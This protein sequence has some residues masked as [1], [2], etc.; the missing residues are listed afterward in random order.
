M[1]INHNRLV[2]GAIVYWGDIV[3]DL[4][5]QKDLVSYISTHGGGGGGG[6]DAAWGSI[7]GNISDQA[8]LMSKFGE[9]A[10]ESFVTSALTG[11]ATQSWVSEQ[12]YLTTE[13][14]SGY[15]TESWVESQGYLTAVPSEYATESWVESQGYL[16]A[17]PSGYAT[18]SWVESQGY[19]TEH[20]DLTGYATESWV[21]SQGYLTSVPSGYATEQFVTN[22]LSGYATESWVGSQGYLDSSSLKTLNSQTLVGEGNIEIQGITS[23]QVSAIAPLVSPSAGVLYTSVSGGGSPEVNLYSTT[24][25]GGLYCQVSPSEVYYLVENGELSATIYRYNNST[26]SFDSVC[27]FNKDG[28][29][30]SQFWKDNT[31]RYYYGVTTQVDLETGETEQVN[32]GESATGDFD[33]NIWKGQYGI[34]L[35]GNE[36]IYKFDEANQEFSLVSVTMTGDNPYPYGSGTPLMMHEYNGHMIGEICWEED[37]GLYAGE[38]NELIEYQDHLEFVDTTSNPY[39]PYWGEFATQNMVKL[40]SDYYFLCW[41]GGA[42]KIVNGEFVECTIY[43][44]G[45]QTQFAYVT[46]SFGLGAE[47][48]DYLVGYMYDPEQIYDGLFPITSISTSLETGWEGLKTVNGQSIIGTGDIQVLPAAPSANGTYTLQLIKSGDTVTYSWVECD[49]SSAITQTN[50]ILS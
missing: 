45:T 13:A 39:I 1:N 17:V 37:P 29:G 38:S 47:C 14:L 43:I 42:Y 31:G 22:S 15:A 6:G 3:G 25:S 35:F 21:S 34:Y 2:P 26:H 50:N 4:T 36:N 48:G 9:Y 20:Q 30:L 40:G 10:T 49:L 11:Y 8:D 12:N 44:S 33:F 18:Q 24:L 7:S 41:G 16:S 46:D 23:S 32:L 28:Y 5:D 27:T 19:L